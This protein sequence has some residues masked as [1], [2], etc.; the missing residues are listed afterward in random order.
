MIGPDVLS[1]LG[2]DVFAQLAILGAALMYAFA[3][4]FGRRFHAAGISPMLASAGQVT[5]SA[6]LLLP[7]AIAVD[8]RIHFASLEA[9]VLASVVALA[10]MSTAV[11]YLIYF[12]ILNS[13]GAVNVM[14]VTFLM[15]VTAILLGVYLLDETLR[16]VELIG[17]GIIALALLTIDGRLPARISRRA[18]RRLRP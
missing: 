10:V 7:V 18:M 11:A 15:P 5:V 16:P 17:M 8:G 12:R 2:R 4:I 9:S 14:L 13:A 3:G 6:L 1:E